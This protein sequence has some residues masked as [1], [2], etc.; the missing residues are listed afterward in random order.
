MTHAR[1]IVVDNFACGGGA[2]TGIETALGRPVDIAINHNAKALAVHLANHPHTLH[3]REDIR[4]LDPR[5]VGP[6]RPVGLG[7]FSPDCT[8]HSKA[9]GGKPF[10]DRNRA[11]RVR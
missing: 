8:Y 4:N 10:R 11:R 5:H 1:E 3:L 7:W 2:S 9:R 6:G